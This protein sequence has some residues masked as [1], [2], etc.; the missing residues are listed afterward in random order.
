MRRAP[1]ARDVFTYF[2][3]PGVL[4]IIL[5]AV[6]AERTLEHPDEPLSGGGRVAL[7]VGVALFLLAA[8]LVRLRIVRLV[9]W[10]RLAGG[11][12]ALAAALTLDRLDAVW[13]VAIVV[14]IVAVT[15]ALE[16]SRLREVR[17]TARTA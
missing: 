11:G 14:A 3:Y 16:S 10:E 15:V 12:A 9:A 2:H 1:L 4:G 8:V 13:L 6:A 5:Y 7:G 17:S